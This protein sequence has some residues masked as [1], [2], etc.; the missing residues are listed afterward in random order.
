MTASLELRDVTK[1]FG[2]FRALTSIDF[3]VAPREFVTIL[4]P[5]G[6]GKS[7]TLRVIGGFETADSGRVLLDGVD[8]T[9]LP[10]EKRDINTSFQG[11]ALFPHMTVSQN[12]AFGLETKGV[13]KAEVKERVLEALTVVK[14]DHYA[15][16]S[17]N[18]LSGGEQQRVALAR[19]FVNQPKVLLLDEPLG[20]LDLKLR[21]QMQ[22]ELK[23]IQ[24]R[25]GITFIYVTHDQEEA[26]SMSDRI[27]VMNQSCIEQ[28]GTPQQIYSSPQTSFV[29]NFL[30]DANVI[31]GKPT[32]LA[33]DAQNDKVEIG[34]IDVLAPQAR[35]SDLED[36]LVTYCLR[37]ERLQIDA[38]HGG[39]D[40]V[41]PVTVQ[42]AVFLGNAWEYNLE[43]QNGLR[44]R[45]WVPVNPNT[46]TFKVG[47]TTAIGWN[48]QD[49]VVIR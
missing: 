46:R 36:G 3:E 25:L 35:D 4:G 9:T 49:M 48:A 15:G 6:S 24:Q 33:G 11:Y 37:A 23:N 19:A 44:L 38:T 16:R 26:L 34:G 2:D 31:T 47:E 29:A 8:V 7:T 5:S 28:I 1:W 18:K 20:A 40:N 22:F 12:V 14:M 39:V 32:G 45:A 21:H 41:C 30:G 17:P 43:G 13:A 10:P 42:A 27:V